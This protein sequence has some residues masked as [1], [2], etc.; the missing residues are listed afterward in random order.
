MIPPWLHCHGDDIIEL[1]WNSNGLYNLSDTSP[2]AV[3]VPSTRKLKIL[4]FF[5]CI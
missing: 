4:E 1:E 3:P 5:R 2:E